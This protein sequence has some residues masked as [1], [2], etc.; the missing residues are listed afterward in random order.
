[1]SKLFPQTS[2][3]IFNNPTNPL[4]FCESF[5]YE[6]SNIE[7]ENL[8]Y[9]YIV[10]QV[11]TYQQ[12]R[13][14]AAY[15][16]NL[17]ATET[18]RNFFKK[19]KKS[20]KEALENTLTHINQIINKSAQD[21]KLSWLKDINLTV[22]LFNPKNQLLSFSSTGKIELLL[23]R[24]GKLVD[25]GKDFTS[26][27]SQ[28]EQAKLF[29][30]VA[31]GRMNPQDR[32]LV[33][34]PPLSDMLSLQKIKNALDKSQY[35]PNSAFKNILN[36]KEDNDLALVFLTTSS[37]PTKADPREKT[38]PEDEKTS[39]PINEISIKEKSKKNLQLN[40]YVLKIK[41][42]SLKIFKVLRKVSLATFQISKQS[43]DKI[44]KE[45]L[46]ALKNLKNKDKKINRKDL[47]VKIKRIFKKIPK[48][49]LYILVGILLLA[50]LL[51]FLLSWD[52]KSIEEIPETFS[53]TDQIVKE[54]LQLV[55][56]KKRTLSFNGKNMFAQEGNLIF[57]DETS[58]FKFNLAQKTGTFI[59]PPLEK[60]EKLLYQAALE[61]NFVYISSNQRIAI[62]DPVEETFN[63]EKLTGIEEEKILDLA[64]YGNNIYLLCKSGKIFK[65]ANLNFSQAITWLEKHEDFGEQ[66]ISFAIDGSIYIL[67]K[68]GLIYK[69][70]RGEQVEDFLITIKG[71]IKQSDKIITSPDFKNIYIMASFQ[72][73]IH[74]FN[75]ETQI[76]IKSLTNPEWQNMTNI[77]IDKDEKNIYL[78]ADS[79]TYKIK[80]P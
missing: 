44:N 54:P 13:S 16:L 21:N 20:P 38:K 74:I 31:N 35:Q 66:F 40:Q 9:L 70:M 57:F 12:N 2:E 28:T 56:L 45:K 47:L 41:N 73:K 49:Y 71:E 27:F 8:G 62:F 6:P 80:I 23:W 61:D 75:R 76:L 42:I 48:K 52:Q 55:D 4:S 77:Y 34:A 58:L 72:N 79:K 17:I 19:I 25:I 24:K 78:L 22:L 7:E 65:Y 36:I 43:F 5:V 63:L 30:N 68:G 51:T 18:S 15:L 39:Q 69:Y 64:T 29:E 3:I 33:S 37:Q 59:F 26:E 11:I 14:Q 60:D 67:E 46:L 10:G 1:M 50:L 53:T 32:L